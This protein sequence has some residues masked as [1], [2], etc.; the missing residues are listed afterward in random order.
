MSQFGSAQFGNSQFT[1]LEVVNSEIQNSEL[2][3]SD[4]KRAIKEYL[5]ES[6][7][8][9]WFNIEDILN[10]EPPSFLLKNWDLVVDL[11]NTLIQ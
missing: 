1:A 4:A 6:F 2:I 10:L 5:Q 11:V 7:D 3:P 9:L 8:N